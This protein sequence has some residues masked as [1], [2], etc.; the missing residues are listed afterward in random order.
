MQHQM[1]CRKTLYCS[2]HIEYFVTIM[3]FLKTKNAQNCTKL[4]CN[5]MDIISFHLTINIA[6]TRT[7]V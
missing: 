6:Y 5:K 2:V 7:G 4:F 1:Q 3:G